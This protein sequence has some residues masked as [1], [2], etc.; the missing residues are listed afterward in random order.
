MQSPGY[1]TVSLERDELASTDSSVKGVTEDSSG[2]SKSTNIYH[3]LLRCSN[4]FC[5]SK[6]LG[7]E[8]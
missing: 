2:I 7:R 4:I 6:V 8:S 5:K 3:I 1:P